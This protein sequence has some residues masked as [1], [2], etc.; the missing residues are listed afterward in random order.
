M[1]LRKGIVDKVTDLVVHPRNKEDVKELVKLCNRERIPVYVFGGGS[2]VNFG[3]RPAKGGIT[4]VLST[5]M[6]K[7]VRLS[8][9]N[10]TV[11]AEAG[12]M[13]PALGL[14]GRVQALGA[15]P[16]ILAPA[17]GQG[18]GQEPG[19]IPIRP[20]PAQGLL[21]A[22][23]ILIR[24]QGHPGQALPAV[25]KQYLFPEKVLQGAAFGQ[26]GHIRLTGRQGPA[27]GPQLL[28]E[29]G[30]GSLMGGQVPGKPLQPEEAVGREK[31]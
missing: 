20:Q 30:R 8:E 5:H 17:Q 11:T 31:V 29:F 3:L 7:V 22:G 27:G 13:G 12:I 10:Q 6:N 1:K 2:S 9:L 26:Q 24:L 18:E 19:L 25:F 23:R 16:D 28:P 14:P 15:L 21:E 4:L